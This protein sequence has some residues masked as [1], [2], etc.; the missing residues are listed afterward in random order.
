MKRIA[1]DLTPISTDNIVGSAKFVQRIIHRL[2]AMETGFS[3][4]FYLQKHINPALLG[5]E[6]GRKDVE[7][8]FVPSL[9]S[10]FKRI[11]F[12]QTLFYFYIKKSDIIYSYCTYIPLLARAKRIITLHDLLPFSF[13]KKHSWFRRNFI[14]AFTKLA[15]ARANHIVTVSEYSKKDIMHFL[16]KEENKITVVYNF[17]GAE[18]DVIKGRKLG[19]D[20][21]IATKE[22]PMTVCKPYICTV[23]SLQPGKNLASLIK[24]FYMFHK[25]NPK[26][27]LYIC[28]GKGWG[29]KE[30]YTLTSELNLMHYVHFTGYIKDEE[31]DK[32]YS[33]CDAVA[34]V[35]YFEGFGIPPLEGFYH[36]KPCIASNTTSLPE[37]VGDG[38][39]LV[40]PY[41][42]ESIATGLFKV[43]NSEKDF[44]HSI[45]KQ[46]EK[47]S[48]EK[49]IIKIIDLFNQINKE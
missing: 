38:G 9:R 33:E 35:S 14:K 6:G 26:Y 41:D 1:F 17:I 49:E 12:Q 8:I 19:E 18:E 3:Y 21:K 16:N 40:D 11:L 43:L 25:H 30:L 39:I 5:I 32:V 20:R 4:I 27:H 48:S 47:F 2:M 44:S 34:Y 42:V 22:G 46:I 29:Y 31:L 28:G 7:I 45:K 36:N 10:R 13:N 15:S 24:A 37:V 23:S